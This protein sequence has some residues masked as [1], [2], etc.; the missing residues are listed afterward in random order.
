MSKHVFGLALLGLLAVEAG[1]Q[2]PTAPTQA[3]VDFYRGN[4]G[5]TGVYPEKLTTPLS[6]L[7]RHTTSSARNN[8]ASPVYANSTAY[9][10]SGGFLYAINA[11][12]G[13]L[14]WQYPQAGKGSSYFA[15]TPALSGGSLYLTDDNGQAYKLD[16]ATGQQTWIRKLDGAIRSAPII[17]G[18]V[19]YFG[20]GNG[21]CYALSAETGQV[22]WDVAADGPVTTSPTVT[23]GL[24]VFASSDDNVYSLNARTG[25]KA[26]AAPF[27]ADPSIVPPVF[28]GATLY[29]TA[30]DTIYRLDPRNAARR[31][32]IKLPTNVLLPPTVSSDSL[33]VVSQSNV[34]YALTSSGRERWRVTLDG[35]ATAPPLLAD[36]LLVVSTQPGVLSG[37][38]VSTG[39]M[40]WRYSMQAS[41]TDSQPKFPSATINASPIVADGTLYVVT[42]DG[43][44]SAFRA[45]APDNIKPQLTQLVPEA[46]AVVRSANL[47]YGALIVDD[48][49]GINPASV[50]LLVDGQADAQAQYHAGQDAVYN[51]PVT[52]LP[53]GQHQ[54]TVKAADWRGNVV[55]QTWSF[56]VQDQQN[57]GRGRGSNPNNPNY[58]G[59]GGRS[60]NAP[61]PPP[62]I[63][64]F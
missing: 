62:P 8:P 51:T 23:G 39:K 60:P 1:A 53:E 55:S 5:H 50:S 27:D 48:G 25:R 4:V 58:P 2:T 64:Q 46:G 30:G 63:G 29:V 20:S 28:D 15:T 19:V 24:V 35:A 3:R 54:I 49:T 11:T 43:S 59:A 38:D 18:G 44:L 13:T 10:T 40:T 16:A 12:D 47:T 34:L 17:S 61:P 45:D 31:G 7:W 57:R 21:H 37:Y 36:N 56:T 26:W 6:L 41:A 42:D 52:P 22:F 33:Y 9:F 14:R 32:P